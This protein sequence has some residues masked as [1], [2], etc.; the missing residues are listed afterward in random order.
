MEEEKLVELAKLA[1]RDELFA[2]KIYSMAAG[3]SKTGST[4]DRLLKISRMEEEHADFWRK[5]LGRR[6]IDPSEVSVGFLKTSLY[7]VFLRLFGLALT[8]RLMES[9]ER[10]AV[11]LYSR[12]LGSPE[13]KEDEKNALKKIL[14]DELV[15]EQEL[16]EEESRF[17]KMLDH[18]RD[19]VLGMNDGLVEIL[20]V[21]MGLVGAYGSAFHVALSGL[22]VAVAGALSMG[23]G[24]FVAARAQRQ[25]H[26]GS[27][28]RIL[29]AARYAAH[30][31]EDRIRRFMEDKGY[32]G[33]AASKVAMESAKDPK[34]M[35][36]IIS[37]EEYGLKEERLEDP[38]AAGL[39]TGLAYLLSALLPIIPYF[40]SLPIIPSMLLSLL[41]AG[42]ALSATGLVIA[43]SANLPVKKK[44]A[45]MVLAGFGSAA[46]TFTLGRI[47]SMIFGV[48]VA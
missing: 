30:V 2:V 13:L 8:F 1:L 42:L 31:F 38:R 48:T 24:A 45:E 43:I 12:M 15:H 26:E 29:L 37:E 35:A 23:I 33:E 40:M 46:A 7:A 14:E 11:E 9:G 10:D 25:V 44:I 27:L 20:S 47:F 32:S 39:Y 18:I 41:I 36:R 21:T 6:G 28:A 22:V 4:R 17:M 19:A 34:L 3:L 5:L 16:A